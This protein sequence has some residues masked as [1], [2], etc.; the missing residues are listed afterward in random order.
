MKKLTTK[1]AYCMYANSISAKIIG[2]N[3]WS[4]DGVEYVVT[5]YFSGNHRNK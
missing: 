1:Q 5:G 4:F 2:D 3:I